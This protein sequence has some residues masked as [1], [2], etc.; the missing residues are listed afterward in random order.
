MVPLPQVDRRPEDGGGVD[1]IVGRPD[2]LLAPLAPQAMLPQGDES[3]EDGDGDGVDWISGLPDEQLLQILARLG[4]ARE[5]ARTGVLSRRWRGLSTRLPAYTFHCVEPDKVEAALA[6]VTR[7]SLDR[8]HITAV[9]KSEAAIGQTS[10]LFRAAARLEPKTFSAA[11]VMENGVDQAEDIELPC[12]HR[13]DSLRLDFCGVGFK[14]PP[15]GEFTELKSLNLATTRYAIPTALLPRCPSLRAL[16]IHAYQGLEVVS[17]SSASLEELAVV[18][19]EFCVHDGF[20]R[21]DI[22]APVVKEVTLEVAMAPDFSLSF[23]AQAVQKLDWNFICITQTVGLPMW[24]LFALN[25]KLSHGVYTLRLRIDCANSDDLPDRS[26]AQELERLPVA[27]FS[28]LE[29]IIQTKGHAFGP[30]LVHLLQIRPAIQSLKLGL[31]ANKELCPEDCPCRQPIDWKHE[32]ISLINLEDV[33]INFKGRLTEQVDF[34][35]LLFRCAPGLKCMKLAVS[36]DKDYE[37]ICHVCE[38]NP[39]VKCNVIRVYST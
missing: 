20:R 26:F 31:Y 18:E 36:S 3:P 13:T 29:L 19:D 21:I 39:H 4:C 17:V 35:K 33:V 14:L 32:N 7:A 34:L 8:L 5:A 1:R 9:L 24:R 38:E 23:S 12:F 37:E 10:S 27:A 15:A 11:L 30:L 6:Q 25:Y 16:R 22:A 2:E 28:V